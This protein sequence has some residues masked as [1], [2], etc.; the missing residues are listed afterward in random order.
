M[1]VPSFW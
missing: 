1:N